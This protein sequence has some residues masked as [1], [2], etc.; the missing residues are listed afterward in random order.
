MAEIALRGVSSTSGRRYL[1]DDVNITLR[2]GELTAIVG[3]QDSG[4]VTILR[5][6]AGIEKVASGDV[7]V[8]GEPVTKTKGGR[9]DVAMVFE[10]QGLLPHKNVFDN[11][12]FPLRM[13]KVDKAEARDRI[14]AAARRFGLE[15]VLNRKPKK[16]SELQRH[17]IGIARAAVREPAAFLFQAVQ[18]KGGDDIR[19]QV[20]KEMVRLVRK[21]GATVVYATEDSAEALRIADRVIVMSF[22]AV[23]Q[24][25][26]PKQIFRR[27]ADKDVAELFGSPPINLLPGKVISQSDG[28]A[29]VRLAG[30]SEISLPAYAKESLVNSDVTLGIRPSHIKL[31]AETPNSFA[32]RVGQKSLVNGKAILELE[33]P[34]GEITAVVSDVEATDITLYLPA[35][36]CILLDSKGT[37]IRR[38]PRKPRS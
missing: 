7:F 9:R 5:V 21:D 1:L 15:G 25:G 22:G 28:M 4:K 3:D 29:Q 26:T 32:A 8:G 38:A 36:Y 33:T 14:H 31:D 6:I 27:P 10:K 20:V 23:A 34:E 2:D 35:D 13:A 12:G 24:V 18:P 30:G 37:L 17:M 16:L 19:K 11:I